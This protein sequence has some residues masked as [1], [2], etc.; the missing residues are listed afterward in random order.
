MRFLAN[1]LW[2]FLGGGLILF[3]EYLIGGFLLCITIIGIPFG[4]QK[5]K[6]ALFALAPFG[7]QVVEN[8]Y[9]PGCLSIIFNILWI[10]LGGFWIAVTHVIFAFLFFI[11]IIGIPFANQHLKMAKL[12]L[13][14]FGRSV[15]IKK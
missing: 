10:L 15:E 6:L 12:A 7:R 14:P 1:L 3:L 2:I 13:V 5:I 11:T 9:A 8:E 4:I